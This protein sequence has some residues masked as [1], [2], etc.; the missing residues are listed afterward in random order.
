MCVHDIYFA[1]AFVSVCVSLWVC[2]L[3]VQ[4]CESVSERRIVYVYRYVYKCARVRVCVQCVC[5]PMEASSRASNEVTTNGARAVC[6]SASCKSAAAS[7]GR[8]SS[9]K[10]SARW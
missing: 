3:Y 7:I 1:I 4:E 6:F 10:H 5:S 2:I 9:H 8:P